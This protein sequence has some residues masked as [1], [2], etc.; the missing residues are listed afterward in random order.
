MGDSLLQGTELQTAESDRTLGLALEGVRAEGK[1]QLL[2]FS[3]QGK[4]GMTTPTC[5]PEG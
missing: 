3:L 1:S 4:N 5:L 2:Q